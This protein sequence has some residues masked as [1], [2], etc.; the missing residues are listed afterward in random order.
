[1]AATINIHAQDISG[2]SFQPPYSLTQKK[3]TFA[4][5]PMQWFNQ[6]WRFDFEMRIGDGPGWLQFGP[7]VYYNERYK[8]DD[9]P[10]YYYDRDNYHFVGWQRYISLREP[11]SKI[12]GGGLDVNYKR[13]INTERSCYFAAGLS[14]THF[15]IDYWGGRWNDYIEDGLLYHAYALNYHT[16]NINRLGVNAYLGRQIPTWNA[17]LF[18]IFCGL[19][20]RHSFSEKD[21][22]AF[23]E[24]KLSYGYTGVVFLAGIRIGFGLR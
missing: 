15:K 14:Y 23:N 17:F 9:T 21:K 10:R 8:N 20:Y 7:A 2:D 16:R 6:A 12:R 4:I 5:Q 18:D 1:L 24:R 3:Y 22:P 19:A 11:Y 13:F